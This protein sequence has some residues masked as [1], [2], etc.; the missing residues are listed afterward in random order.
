[1]IPFKKV[2]SLEDVKKEYP[3]W[4]DEKLFSNTKVKE[5]INEEYKELSA[6]RVKGNINELAK[7]RGVYRYLWCLE[8]CMDQM[9]KFGWRTADLHILIKRMQ[10]MGFDPYSIT[11]DTAGAFIESLPHYGYKIMK[12]KDGTE[13]MAYNPKGLNELVWI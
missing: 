7:F 11:E 2:N 8:H 5:L 4:F 10:I 9:R 6:R 3:Y 1:M 13:F 12:K